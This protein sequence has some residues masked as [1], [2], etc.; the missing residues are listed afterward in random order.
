MKVSALLP[1]LP[2]AALLVACSKS[3]QDILIA[4]CLENGGVETFCSCSADV[5]AEQ[6]PPVIYDAIVE[7]MRKG[8]SRDEAIESLPMSQQLQLLALFP[9]EMSC[10]V[11]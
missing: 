4:D 9:A 1:L 3:D 11:E 7:D 10:P 8:S 5:M 2:A 6:A